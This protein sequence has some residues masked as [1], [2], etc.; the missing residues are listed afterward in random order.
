MSRLETER[1]A[2]EA[3]KDRLQRERADALVDGTASDIRRIEK[4]VA[5][6][7]LEMERLTAAVP[8]LQRRLADARAREAAA[9]L[10][11]K[12]ARATDAITKFNRWVARGFV[13]SEAPNLTPPAE[14]NP[15][16]IGMRAAG[17][18]QGPTF[19]R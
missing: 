11:E 16:N 8:V 2:L 6:V 13:Q 12:A 4:A 14:L 19:R 1:Q 10:G 5:D 17:T 9:V 3:N 15:A 7:E 18:I